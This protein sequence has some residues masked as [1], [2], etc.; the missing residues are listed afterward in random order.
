[1]H[2]S[3]KE[4]EIHVKR[5]VKTTALELG[6][7]ATTILLKAAGGDGGD[8]GRGGCGGDGRCG[9]DGTDATSSYRGTNGGNGGD[10]GKGGNGGNGGCG[11]NGGSIEV[12]T[13][14]ENTDLFALVH[15]QSVA[16]GIGGA[17]GYCGSGGNGGSR[18]RGGSA[19]YQRVLVSAGDEESGPVYREDRQPGGSDGRSGRD[20]ADGQYGCV[21][22]SGQ[23]GSYRF[24]VGKD[25]YREIYNLAITHSQLK[26]ANQDG[27]YEPGERV[28]VKLTLK[29]T[30]AMET[31]T[32]PISVKLKDTKWT[33]FEK[34]STQYLSPSLA[35]GC[36]HQLA[37]SLFFR[38][39]EC[40]LMIGNNL[41]EQAQLLYEAKLERIN[42]T[43][44]SVDAQATNFQVQ[45]PVH[46]L[47]IKG[48]KVIAHGE[49]SLIGFCLKN[50]SKKAL[51]AESDSKRE[52]TLSLE[53]DP[54]G[55]V[56]PDDVHFFTREVQPS[57]GARGIY[58][59]VT[60]IDKDASF[61]FS[62]SLQFINPLTQP[63]AKVRLIASLSLAH[64]DEN[65]REPGRCIQK[66]AFE[67]QLAES[68]I[69]S[70]SMV[71]DSS[72]YQLVQ[73]VQQDFLLVTNTETTAQETAAWL[74]LANDLGLSFNRW[75]SS[76]YNGISLF[77]PLGQNGESLINDFTGRTI[78]F[79]NNSFKDDQEQS[80]CSLDMLPSQEL[81]TATRDH[82]VKT[83]VIGGTD[84]QRDHFLPSAIEVAALADNVFHEKYFSSNPNVSK[85]DFDAK[86][87]E[88]TRSLRRQDPRIKHIFIS[89]FGLEPVA[90]GWLRTEFLLGRVKLCPFGSADRASFLKVNSNEI[91]QASFVK[92]QKNAYCLL[93]MLPFER[94]LLALSTVKPHYQDTLKSAILSDLADE[95]HAF[96]Y[97]NSTGELSKERI[98]KELTL[99]NAILRWEWSGDEATA[100]W[101]IDLLAYFKAYAERLPQKRDYFILNRRKR[102]LSNAVCEMIDAY[103]KANR[104]TETGQ[105]A[106]LKHQHALSTDKRQVVLERM[107]NPLKLGS[108]YQDNWDLEPKIIKESA[109]SRE[110]TYHSTVNFNKNRY[111]TLEERAAALS[112]LEARLVGEI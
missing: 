101:L 42:Q 27:I 112:L 110:K 69:P 33:V 81:F 20:G 44:A 107:R 87:Y 109:V 3:I 34:G 46:I 12:A 89:S 98:K 47:P 97:N 108:F 28:E 58:L 31:P 15:I 41:K 22:R 96:C 40:A 83:Y 29:N 55:A 62:S 24:K 52:L 1:L 10:G 105:R 7:V 94:K 14:R 48:S 21:G 38:I 99:L 103:Y 91:H 95:Q 78:V 100:G 70:R 50:I 53:V 63:Y 111:Y 4:Q 84:S 93:K 59:S 56:K 32:Q 75:N 49:H 66:Q 43:F 39:K 57:P 86:V 23:K 64:V 102:I 36:E 11:G 6:N 37:Q 92:S 25:E 85:E 2:L 68:Y 18:G 8:G 106:F 82:H 71:V 65:L 77:Q 60:K 16:G 67:V 79:L 45:H 73:G 74:E 54:Q 72:V 80:R 5:G 13:D 19:Y 51:G 35:M 9:Y 17:R 88:F 26:D 76:L 30:G 90:K 61:A 104:W